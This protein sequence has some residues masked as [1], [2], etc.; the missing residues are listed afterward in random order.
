VAYFA[1]DRKG[2]FG[3]LDLYYFELPE[4]FRPLQVNYFKG[5]VFDARSKERL[6]ARFELID[7]STNQVVIESY[8]DKVSGEFLVCLPS[9]K[10]YALNVSRNGY[11]FYS[12]N[13]RLE[14]S[15][16]KEPVLKDVPMQPIDKGSS[17]V[18]NNVFFDTDQFKLKPESK[19]ELDKLVTF[20]SKNAELKIELSGH[21][22]NVGNPADNQTLSE[23]RAKAVMDYLIQNGIE[24]TRLSAVGFGDTKPITSNDTPKGRAENRRT[25]FRVL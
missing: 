1:S 3:N 5:K 20:L 12:E 9:G 4:K 21:T 10:N 18:L 23:N 15:D 22:D 19:T 14:Q 16:S 7:L 8:S 11:L 25:E 6:A 13:F 24:A 17:I 2:G